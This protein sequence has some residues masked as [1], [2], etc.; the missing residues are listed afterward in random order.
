MVID[1][2]EAVSMQLQFNNSPLEEG[3]DQGPESKERILSF[4]FFFFAIGGC[5]FL[6][7]RQ[8][9]Q[10]PPSPPR[11]PEKA[12]TTGKREVACFPH[13]AS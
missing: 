8:P 7:L 6:C 13:F 10:T 11:P 1:S 12:E 3:G 5:C 2:E 4:L 9:T